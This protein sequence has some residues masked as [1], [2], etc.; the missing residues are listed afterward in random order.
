MAAETDKFA[1]IE[2]DH[3]ETWQSFCRGASWISAFVIVLLALMAIFL[4]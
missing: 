2:R 1:A 4:V 3:R